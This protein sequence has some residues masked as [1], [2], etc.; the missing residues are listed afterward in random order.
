MQFLIDIITKSQLGNIHFDA[1]FFE[2]GKKRSFIVD[3]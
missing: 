1:G 2:K 3:M